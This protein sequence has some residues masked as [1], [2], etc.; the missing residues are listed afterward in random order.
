MTE[1]LIPVLFV[2]S[3]VEGISK[4]TQR[5]ASDLGAWLCLACRGMNNRS[6]AGDG[7][8]GR[9]SLEEYVVACRSRLRVLTR[10][11]KD[12]VLPG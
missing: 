2:T 7:L 10:V 9:F 6:A 8:G 3:K 5:Q 11:P 12:A 1:N 4:L